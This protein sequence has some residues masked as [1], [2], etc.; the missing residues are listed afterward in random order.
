MSMMFTNVN[1]YRD[2]LYT[3]QMNTVNA[4]SFLLNQ[5]LPKSLVTQ[6]SLKVILVEVGAEPAESNDRLTPAMP[7]E[8][9]FFYESKLL[10][11]LITTY[12]GLL[13]QLVIP[14]ASR[15]T[16][17]TVYEAMPVPMPQSSQNT[18]LRWKLDQPFLAV[19]EYFVKEAA[20]D[21]FHLQ[22]CIGND[23][24]QI[25]HEST[26]TEHGHFSCLSTLFCKTSIDS[27]KVCDTEEYLLPSTETAENLGLEF[28]SSQQ[29]TANTLPAKPQLIHR[30]QDLD[31]YF[32]AAK[33][34]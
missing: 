12:E 10:N 23:H 29:Q 28:G 30:S 14:L 24:Y 26:A 5:L 32:Q 3:Y 1:A 31:K 17:I 4:I 19:S 25:C 6:D 20:L 15:K 11:Y 7:N 8:I 13:M 22:K 33:F 9:I 2:A 21:R 27:I 16:A 18:A 34:V